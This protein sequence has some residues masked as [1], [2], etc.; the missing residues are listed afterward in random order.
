M[1]YCLAD[2]MF[3]LIIREK[4]MNKKERRINNLLALLQESPDLSVKSLAETLSVSDMTIRRDLQY[5][6]KNKLFLRNHGIPLTQTPANN[7]QNI[8]NEYTLYSE[9]LKRLEEKQRIGSFAISMLEENDT[10]I[11]DSG[12][13]IAEMSR[14]I[15]EHQNLNVICYNYYILTQLFHKEGVHITLAG[16]TLHKDDQMIESSYGT[17]LIRSQRACK[18]FMAAS[19]IHEALGITC[20][21][22]YEVMTKRAAM[23][24]S[25]TAILLADSS[26]FGLIR[27]AY[28]AQ[29]N[30]INTIVTDTG[31]SQEWADTIRDMGII[32]HLV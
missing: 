10:V 15:P 17:D 6:R 28:V 26:K 27:S 20:A 16:G 19:G 11:L 12:T 7:I 18:F 23:Q 22:N 21:H 9:R 2:K 30:E 32:L 5:L 25:L 1:L 13:T 24:S 29:L 14:Y 8:E 31:L 3:V 4:S